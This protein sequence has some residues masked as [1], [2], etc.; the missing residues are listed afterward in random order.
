MPPRCRRTM[1]EVAGDSEGSDG[2]GSGTQGAAHG[3]LHKVVVRIPGHLVAP[4][5]RGAEEPDVRADQPPTT[6]E[7]AKVISKAA[8]AGPASGFAISG[9][10][11]PSPVTVKVSPSLLTWADPP[12]WPLP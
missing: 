11:M 4:G 6:V 5:M 2:E 8:V 10:L 12:G 1:P 7:Q 3:C 9:A